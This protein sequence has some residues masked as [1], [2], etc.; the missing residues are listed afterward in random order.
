MAKKK[1]VGYTKE[2]FAQF[3]LDTK[4]VP[5]SV[6]ND[7]ITPS[8]VKDELVS[9][10]FNYKKRYDKPL[11]PEQ[12]DFL[13][14]SSRVYLQ[15]G[16]DKG[17]Q[18]SVYNTPEFRKPMM[19]LAKRGLPEAIR[20]YYDYIGIIDAGIFHET[21]RIANKLDNYKTANVVSKGREAIADHISYEELRALASAKRSRDPNNRVKNTSYA[22]LMKTARNALVEELN[23]T[24]EY[25]KKFP[26]LSKPL[27][28][29]Q[30]L[31]E[32]SDE[33][34]YS[35][36]YDLVYFKELDNLLHTSKD[37][38][39]ESDKNMAD[40]NL[41]NL[42]NAAKNILIFSAGMVRPVFTAMAIDT[43]KEIANMKFSALPTNLCSDFPHLETQKDKEAKLNKFINNMK[44]QDVELGSAW[45]DDGKESKSTNQ[46]E[47]D[48][49]DK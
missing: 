6:I 28:A 41:L 35:M 36:F 24:K 32:Y 46:H 9:S 12:K 47:N 19:W 22:S 20:V 30:K 39:I 17:L 11:T 3:L 38:V 34:G 26:E 27:N 31:Y 25:N 13:I 49:M 40:E 10:Y 45:K 5:M 33:Y 15:A 23:T 29:M 2:E 48:G 14:L 18:E 7:K 8:S 42:Y 4:R 37:L 43:L 21:Q 44:K 16:N 1:N